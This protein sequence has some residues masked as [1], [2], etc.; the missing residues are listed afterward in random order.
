M[1]LGIFRLIWFIPYLLM[2]QLR[3][4]P[5]HQQA[6]SYQ[7]RIK[8]IVLLNCEFGR[9][10]LNTI[11]DMILNVNACFMIVKTICMLRVNSC[12]TWLWHDELYLCT[13]LFFEMQL[14]PK[15]LRSRIDMLNSI[16]LYLNSSSSNRSY[17]A[18]GLY[19]GFCNNSKC[20]ILYIYTYATTIRI[21]SAIKIKNPLSVTTK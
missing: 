16:P 2:L 6:W 15:P 20:I 17:G 13:M 1:R 12:W 5:E 21:V 3:K 10:Q 8:Y 4:S 11:K 14:H 7:N 18:I 19:W 9:L